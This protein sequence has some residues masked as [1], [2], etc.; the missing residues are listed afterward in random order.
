[1]RGE[2][3]L[4]SDWRRKRGGRAAALAAA[5]LGAAPAGAV[6]TTQRVASGLARPVYAT[7]PP[8][9]YGRLFVVEQHSGRIKILDLT[10]LEIAPTPFLTIG[11]LARGQEQGLLGLAFHPDYAT[12]GFFYVNRTDASG[13]TRIERYQVSSDPGIAN[14]TAT[15]L[16]SIPQPQ[17]NHNGGWLGFGPDGYLYISTGDGGGSDDNDAGHTP[18]SGNAQ[19]LTDNLLG[20]ILRIDVDSSAPGRNYGI[21][22]TN[23]FVGAPGDDEIWAYGLRNPWRASFDR[24]TGDLW[25]GDVGGIAR[26]ELNLQPAAS[27]GGENYGWRLRE[28]MIATPTPFPP[29]PPV[30][31]PRPPGAIDPIHDYPH[32]SAER[33]R[34]VTGGYVYRGPIE[35]LR[36]KYFF[37][38]FPTQHIWS[39]TFDGSLPGDF[40]GTNFVDFQEWTDLLQPLEGELADVSSFAEDAAGNLYL[41]DLGGVF[42]PTPGGGEIYRL[43]P[44]PGTGLLLGAG[45]AALAGGSPL[46]ARLRLAARRPTLESA[47]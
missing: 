15:P 37:A 29:E 27:P 25:I 26:E 19:D 2:A 36:G 8:G 9:D 11:D 7:A 12:N 4:R 10:T 28:G 42:V 47:S 16:L 31:G 41:L 46:F 5:L 23:P 20:K 44:E 34:A 43:V 6:V 13:T 18:E 24:Q 39:I 1:V 21:P 3:A 35:E 45:L 30:G 22:D 40:D 33:I 38:D 14:P 32:T 17:Q